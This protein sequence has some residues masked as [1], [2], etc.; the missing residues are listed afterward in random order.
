MQMLCLSRRDRV[1]LPYISEGLLVAVDD[2]SL[3]LLLLIRYY[4]LFARSSSKYVQCTYGTETVTVSALQG[5]GNNFQ[6]TRC[7]NTLNRIIV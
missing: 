7:L 5:V 3:R 2:L 6:C 4:L 1:L